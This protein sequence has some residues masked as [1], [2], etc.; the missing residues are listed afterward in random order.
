MMPSAMWDYPAIFKSGIEKLKHS[1]LCGH[2]SDWH[3]FCLRGLSP[4]HLHD[5]QIVSVNCKSVLSDNSEHFDEIINCT[6]RG[7]PM[8]NDLYYCLSN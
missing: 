1:A 6:L 4:S 5:L 7:F 2:Y 3:G 8:L